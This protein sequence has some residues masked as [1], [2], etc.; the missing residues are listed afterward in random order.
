MTS[1]FLF[2]TLF[3]ITQLYAYTP[4]VES[5]FRNG[6]N[7]DIG[8]NTIIANLKIRKKSKPADS[9]ETNSMMSVGFPEQLVK[10]YI[11][12]ENEKEPKLVQVNFS[13]THVK[14]EEITSVIY[15]PNYELGKMGFHDENILGKMFYSIMSSVLNNDG[16]ML[17]L[18]LQEQGV[19]VKLNADL[20]N[21]EKL[22][23]LK[24]YSEYL[25]L[26]ETDENL[27]NPL[28]S[29]DSEK[30]AEIDNLMRSPFY[31]PSPF[32]TKVRDGDEFNWLI[33]SS[34]F[35]A[36]VSDETRQI[37]YIKFN[38]SYGELKFLFDS[39]LISGSNF[40]VP[41]RI[42]VFDGNRDVFEV[43]ITRIQVVDDKN[44]SYERRFKE[45]LESKNR[46]NLQRPVKP[47]FLL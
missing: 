25:K 41:K 42:T 28:K 30:Q 12:N 45:F 17:V 19:P 7:I 40:E 2:I 15:R 27:K 36:K 24:R 47:S 14:D 22:H 8:S 32:V 31:H 21:R 3:S 1:K 37:K 23:L 34:N 38:S 46:N 44:G 33:K 16:K 11:S 18:F 39:Y 43:E 13:G 4:T 5:L 35:E 6:N 10:F 20:I 29:D 26:S 9:L